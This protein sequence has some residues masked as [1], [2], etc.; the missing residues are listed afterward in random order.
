MTLHELRARTDGLIQFMKMPPKGYHIPAHIRG[1]VGAGMDGLY[2]PPKQ[3]HQN[4]D[5]VTGILKDQ[6]GYTEPRLSQITKRAE[7]GGIVSTTRRVRP[8]LHGV[9]ARHEVIHSGQWQKAGLPKTKAGWLADET[10][11]YLGSWFSPAGKRTGL[12]VMERLK[13][14]VTGIQHSAAHGIKTNNIK[15]WFNGIEPLIQL[16]AKTDTLLKRRKRI[17]P[18]KAGEYQKGVEGTEDFGTSAMGARI[19]RLVRFS[20]KSAMLR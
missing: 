15:R 16:R 18:N 19:E 9:L 7:T 13:R 5:F 17:G 6:Y 14:S 8:P 10:G 1:E 20:Q 4:K 3:Y 12:G 2:V 11:A